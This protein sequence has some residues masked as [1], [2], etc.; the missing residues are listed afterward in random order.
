MLIDHRFVG[1]ILI[2][3]L[4]KK[5]KTLLGLVVVE[6]EDGQAEIVIDGQFLVC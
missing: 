3:I 1:F 2:Q 4:L 5:G 6:V